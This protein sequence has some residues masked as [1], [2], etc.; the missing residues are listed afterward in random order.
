MFNKNDSEISELMLERCGQSYV[1]HSP[2]S[3]FITNMIFTCI[4]HFFLFICGTILNL[5]VIITFWLSKTLRSKLS[6]FTVMV[7]SVNDLMVTTI[8]HPI[9]ITQGIQ[10]ILRQPNCMFEGVSDLFGTLLVGLSLSTLCVMN[11]ERFLCIYYPLWHKANVTKQRLL[12][13][14]VIL[15]SVTLLNTGPCYKLGKTC[16]TII[17]P[18]FSISVSSFTLFVYIFIFRVRRKRLKVVSALSADSNVDQLRRNQ[19]FLR[20]LK[21]ARHYIHIVTLTCVCYAPVTIFKFMQSSI[22]TGH[23]S[24]EALA[25]ALI[26]GETLVVSLS[27]INCVLFFW[28]NRELKK[29]G[30]KTIKKIMSNDE[31]TYI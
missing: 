18:T 25:V 5:T 31:V 4:A 19:S 26:W 27:T 9:F 30:L 11:A 1:V 12:L 2:S 15:W 6:V 28:S 10:E 17:V 8:T 23:Q 16:S 13:V 7:L 29:E 3:T 22:R 24:S 14:C 20:D 21:I